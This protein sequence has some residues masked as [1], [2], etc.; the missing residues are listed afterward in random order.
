MRTASIVKILATNRD[1]RKKVEKALDTMGFHAGRAESLPANK[2]TFDNFFSFYRHLVGR[3]E[4]DK[5][6]DELGAKKKPYLTKDQFCDFLN[7]QQRDPRLNEIL[8]PNYSLAQA[9]ALIHRFEPRSSMAQKAFDP[10][11]PAK[12]NLI[13]P[14][15]TSFNA[16]QSNKLQCRSPKEALIPLS[17][18]SFN[19][20]QPNEL[21]CR[22]AKEALIPLSQTSFNAAQPNKL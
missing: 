2:L 16:A 7:K 6:F 20:A 3:T 19:A 14:T 11:G 12:Q 22:S 17:Q 10:S 21:Q 9:D 4:V 1:D 5:I 13:S 8:Y 15:Q 18:T